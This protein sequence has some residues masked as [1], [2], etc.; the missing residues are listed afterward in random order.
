M[1]VQLYQKSHA[2]QYY[3]IMGF[4]IFISFWMLR[5]FLSAPNWILHLSDLTYAVYLFHMWFFEYVKKGLEYCNILLFNA[6]MQ[7]LIIL[8]YVSFIMVKYI[9]KPGVELGRAMLNTFKVK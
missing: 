4:V 1:L 9:E 2:G 8:F 6:D 3:A 5:S 7:A